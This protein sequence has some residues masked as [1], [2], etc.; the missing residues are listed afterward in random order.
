MVRLVSQTEYVT[1]GILLQT[2]YASLNPPPPSPYPNDLP[3]QSQHQMWLSRLQILRPDVDDV[4]ADGLR[5][6]ECQRQVLVYLV[7][8]QLAL[9]NGSLVYRTRLGLVDHFAER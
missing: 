9:V 7:N 8:T 5:R 2:C 6:V 3:Q 4:T 1:F